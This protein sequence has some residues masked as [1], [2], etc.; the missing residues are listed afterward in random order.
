MVLQTNFAL[1]EANEMLTTKTRTIIATAVA[2][3]SFAATTLAPAVSQARP[4]IIATKPPTGQTCNVLVESIA[5][6]EAEARDYEKKGDT[7][8][9]DAMWASANLYFA[10]WSATGCANAA[11][12]TGPSTV[13]I[14]ASVGG[15]SAT[16]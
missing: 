5:K 2:S 13:G 12:V 16:R 15:V 7:K 10:T 8:S 6:A 1:Q 9:A 3:L 4:K 11:A 14:A